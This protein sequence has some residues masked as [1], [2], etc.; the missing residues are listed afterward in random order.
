MREIDLNGFDVEV[1]QDSRLRFRLV[2]H[3]PP[4]NNATGRPINAKKHGANSTI[5][6]FDL[7][8]GSKQFQYVKT[9]NSEAV[10]TPNDIVG[11]GDGG[12]LVTN[13][14]R[15]KSMIPKISLIECTLT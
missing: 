7:V 11:T 5:E 12:F 10:Y 8:R 2:N 6:V 15:S 1:L 4:T 13:D 3:R 14:H 9:V